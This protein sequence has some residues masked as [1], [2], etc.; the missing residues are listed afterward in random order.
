MSN[1]V[2][3]QTSFK[4]VDLTPSMVI[5]NWQDEGVPVLI[6]NPEATLNQR[7]ALAWVTAS[8]TLNILEASQFAHGS[9]PVNDR[10]VLAVV[11][12][13]MQQLERMLND[14]G[15]RTAALEGGAS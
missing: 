9:D 11:I 3:L 12:G 7:A 13:R 10:A 14:I 8:D 15:D 2:N 1:S 4:T 5:G 6:I